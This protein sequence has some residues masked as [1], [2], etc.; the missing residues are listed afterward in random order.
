M[1]D[2]TRET[3]LKALKALLDAADT[4]SGVAPAIKRNE[5]E[6]AD[7]PAGGLV[8]LRDGDPGDPEVYLS[9]P[10]YAFSHRAE[11]VVQVQDANAAA[12]DAALDR[13]LKDLGAAID[14]DPTL[15][16]AVEM[17]AA[18]LADSLEEPVD[19]AATIKA[20]VVAVVLEYVAASPLG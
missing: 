17:A 7:I 15:G 13:I 20:A 8:V 19:G 2:S 3:A 1:A 6:A 10:A 4:W 18:S 12:R 11:V 16:G 5:P 9:P 14:A